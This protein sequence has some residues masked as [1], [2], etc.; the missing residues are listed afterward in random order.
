MFTL[1]TL[2]RAL[3]GLACLATSIAVFYAVENWRGLRA[4]EQCKRE[5]EAK[6]EVMDWA[7]FIPPPVPDDQNIFKAPHMAE[8]FVGRGES[9]FS[10]R[11]A[12]TNTASVG[13]D[14]NTITTPAA[15]V[16]YLK[17]SDQFEHELSMISEALKRPYARIDTHYERPYEMAIPN[18][19]TLRNVARTLAQRSHCHLLLGQPEMARQ[20]LT[21]L[22]DLCRMT[23]ARPTGKPMTLVAAMINVAITGLYA[24][25]IAEGTQSHAWQ[26][27]QLAALQ[28]QLGQ[29]N[30]V[31]ILAGAFKDERA[32]TSHALEHK[33]VFTGVPSTLMQRLKDPIYLFLTF[34]PRGWI[35]QNMVAG[36]NH[37][38]VE[39]FDLKNNLV[40]PRQSEQ[41]SRTFQSLKRSWSSP[42]VF[43]ATY[44][45]PNFTLAIQRL[46]RNQTKV[47]QALIVC[48]LERYRL[49]HGQYPETLDALAPQFI[50]PLP[51]DLIG[52]Q[53]LKYRRNPD[54]SFTLY[55]IGW[56][57]KD[58][59]GTP[60][61]DEKNTEGDW[62]WDLAA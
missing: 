46:A 60:G 42:Y 22:R 31:P 24:N 2:R 33:M 5:L 39:A 47:N 48:A 61:Q 40:L 41:A 52:G 50:T 49:A 17:W 38:I 1:Q 18:F 53:P 32:A 6:G 4:W 56:N 44:A 26:E 20:E 59:G 21:L 43:L 55:S 12:N 16:D 30:L 54:G 3:V 25:S 13:T 62:I 9:E 15:A 8:W 7:R 45:L 14:H 10:K 19:I 37:S 57:E 27:P 23:E 36:V 11:L 35:Y 28:N 29:I 58:D 34:A 51:H